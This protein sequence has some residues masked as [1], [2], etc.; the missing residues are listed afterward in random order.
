M[1]PTKHQSSATRTRSAGV[2]LRRVAVAEIR[3]PDAVVGWRRVPPGV[4]SGPSLDRVLT[5]APL[6]V[7]ESKDGVLTAIT[8]V[9]P[10]LAA[11]PDNQDG[12]RYVRCL[13]VNDSE[14][15]IDAWQAIVQWVVPW[16]EGRLVGR[17]KRRAT[18][19][20][21]PY[22]EL[23]ELVRPRSP[24][25]RASYVVQADA[26]GSSSSERTVKHRRA[27]TP[28]HPDQRTDPTGAAPAANP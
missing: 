18:R 19:A 17:G 8:D 3:W 16:L 27:T 24:R 26:R 28:R 6:V 15:S 12:K 23:A 14:W 20:L 7:Y 22:P 25:T 13:V 11:E 4:V 10:L 21:K 5:V 2:R 1:A 9:R